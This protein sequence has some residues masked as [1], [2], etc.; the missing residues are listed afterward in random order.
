MA[1]GLNPIHP[2]L[3]R[4][5]KEI[6][7]CADRFNPNSSG[8]FEIFSLSFFD[9]SLLA[10][11]TEHERSGRALAELRRCVRKFLYIS[12]VDRCADQRTRSCEMRARLKVAI[13]EPLRAPSRAGETAK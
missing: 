12:C 11:A 13:L 8:K 10:R 6:E 2:L 5:G 4:E 9:F 3:G 7:K 1:A